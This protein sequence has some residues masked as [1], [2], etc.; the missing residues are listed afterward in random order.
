MSGI[1]LNS[2]EDLDT[3]LLLNADPQVTIVVAPRERFSFTRESLESI[4]EHTEIPF[5]L[6]YVDGGSPPQTRRY[7]EEQVRAKEFQLIRTDYYLSPNQA[8]NLGLG[9]VKSKYV[10]FIDNDVVVTPNW[11]NQLVQCAEETGATVVGPL[12]CQGQP[13]HEIVHFA[14]GEARILLE[15]KGEKVKRRILEKIYK[16]GQ[17]VA[18]VRDHL[19]RLQTELAE[20]HCMMVNRSIFEQVG[21]LDETIMN[22]K[23]HVDFCMLVSQAE[24]KVYFE[25]TSVVTYVPGPPLEWSDIP[26]YML[27]WSN[28]WELSSLHRL[29]DKWDL[30]EDEYFDN[31]YKRLGWRRNMTIIQ[32]LASRL[33]FGQKKSL[34]ERILFFMDKV[35]SCY[36]TTRHAH[37][38]KERQSKQG[39]CSQPHP[40]S[41][42][43]QHHR[44][45]EDEANSGSATYRA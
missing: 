2:Q 9:Q 45:A 6:V 34:F 22:T 35:L 24:G 41:L 44:V 27:R 17:R 42:Q 16:Q 29:R 20:F 30:T 10:V 1:R 31:R 13:V 28:A 5:K 37:K 12:I 11:L 15:N 8:R 23:E 14:G 38:E 4:Y 36:L 43:S 39:S 21:S 18:D 26:F 7:L 19:Q 32:P 33:A 3:E 40:I 25:P